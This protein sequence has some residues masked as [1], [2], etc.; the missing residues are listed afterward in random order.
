MPPR[1]S[2]VLILANL[3]VMLLAE[4]MVAICLASVWRDP[5]EAIRA[6]L[7]AGWLPLGVA[8]VAYLAAFCRHSFSAALL[9]GLGALAAMLGVAVTA[10][11]LF[12]ESLEAKNAATSLGGFGMCCLVGG[13]ACWI[14]NLAWYRE[15]DHWK[16]QEQTP[17]A[18]SPV[19]FSLRDVLWLTLHAALILGMSRAISLGL[20]YPTP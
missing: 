6:F 2:L 14:T 4:F 11:V 16:R 12:V 1:P 3:A 8:L 13:F 7:C 18:E 5:R 10:I 15:L 20:K 19:K 9:T 17:I